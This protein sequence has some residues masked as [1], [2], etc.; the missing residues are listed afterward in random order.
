MYCA[1]V[2]ASTTT[3]NSAACTTLFDR[4]TPIAAPAIAT[5]MIQKATSCSHISMARSLLLALLGT[6]LQRLGFGHGGHPL[7]ELDLVMEQLGDVALGVLVLGAPEQ[8]VERAHLDADP[9]VH[10]ERIVDVEAVEHA[11]RAL[12]AALAPRWSLLLVALD[13]DAPV[14][15]GARAQHADRA[16]LLLQR[17]DATSARDGIFLLVRVLDRDRRLQHRLERDA[18]AADHPGS[19]DLPA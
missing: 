18:E 4:T 6:E 8:G 7:A 9:A 14:G 2:P 16:V 17:D 15:T 11:H 19:G 13:V 10:A 12:A 1:A 5:A 3:R